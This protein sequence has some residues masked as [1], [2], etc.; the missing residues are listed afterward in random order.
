[1]GPKT[2]VAEGD[3]FRQPLREPDQPEAPVGRF[4]RPDQLGT[5]G[6]I[7]ERELRITQ[8]STSELAAPDCP[9]LLLCCSTRFDLSDEEVVWQWVENP[10]WQVFTGE[11]LL[12]TEPPI[13]PSSL[14]R[15]RKRPGRG[16]R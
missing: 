2:P 4:G 11:T 6:R 8:G 7:D 13:D 14:T 3:F 12:Q 1:M 15:W 10:Y 9:G 16:R 5:I